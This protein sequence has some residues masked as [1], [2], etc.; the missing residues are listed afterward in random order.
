[1]AAVSARGVVMQFALVVA[2]FTAARAQAAAP[3][4]SG[5]TTAW[6]LHKTLNKMKGDI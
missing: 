4:S 2:F 1:M 5:A 6:T 3:T